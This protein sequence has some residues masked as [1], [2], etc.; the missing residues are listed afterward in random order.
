MSASQQFRSSPS[1]ATPHYT[2]LTYAVK[3]K[4]EDETED[5]KA[6]SSKARPLV[7]ATRDEKPPEL[8]KLKP[9]CGYAISEDGQL[10]SRFVSPPRFG[11]N[12]L[13]AQQQQQQQPGGG[14]G[15][16]VVLPPASV[17]AP[18][19]VASPQRVFTATVTSDGRGNPRISI[20]LQRARG[21]AAEAA[22][23]QRQLEGLDAWTALVRCAAADGMTEDDVALLEW[24]TVLKL[25]RHY[26]VPQAESSPVEKARCELTWRRLH[27]AAVLAAATASPSS[28]PAA[29][30]VQPRAGKAS[31]DSYAE[32]VRKAADEFRALVERLYPAPPIMQ[33]AGGPVLLVRT[34][35]QGEIEINAAT[36]SPRRGGDG[37]GSAAAAGRQQPIVHLR[38]MDRPGAVTEELDENGLV[39]LG[40]KP[41]GVRHV[42]P[43]PQSSPLR[44]PVLK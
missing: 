1:R 32:R 27:D 9:I 23:Q 36:A 42:D 2:H 16:S 25:L 13:L 11:P 37:N 22:E 29:A 7:P 44:R 8:P 19:T 26:A 21:T 28:P 14:G 18:N 5:G 30:Q 17:L 33:A 35:P 41:F 31:G 3:R 10:M 6:L 39:R 38:K 40:S 34:A 20:P 12:S 15:G 24:T 43:G 4:K